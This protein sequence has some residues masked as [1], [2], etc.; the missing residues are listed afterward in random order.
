MTSKKYTVRIEQESSGWVGQIIR[1]ASAKKSVV[2]KS[3]SGFTT[4]SEAQEWGESELQS[5][6]K[7]LGERNKRRAQQRESAVSAP[8]NLYEMSAKSEVESD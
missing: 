3:Q 1:R 2:S 8:N 6:L 4:E 7:S 5:F